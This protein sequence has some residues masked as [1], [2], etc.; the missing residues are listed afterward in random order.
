MS[1]FDNQSLSTAIAT[2]IKDA[3]IPDDHHNAFALIGT[4][5]GG[6][7]GVLTTKVG[8]HWQVD[9]MFAVKPDKTFEGGVQV[10]ATW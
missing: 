4:T 1:I 3:G 5:S 8:D 7:K 10:K 2:Q 9:S 6:V